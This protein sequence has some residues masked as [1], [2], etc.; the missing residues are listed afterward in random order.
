MQERQRERKQKVK[1]K[2]EKKRNGD[3]I[4]G[5]LQELSLT[6]ATRKTG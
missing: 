3:E 4:I 5:C 1:E 2:R 6:N